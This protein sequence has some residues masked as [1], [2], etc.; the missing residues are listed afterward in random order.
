VLT[1]TGDGTIAT[2]DLAVLHRNAAAEI[3]H[4]TFTDGVLV[5]RA[6]SEA[7]EPDMMAWF[8]DAE[9]FT[10]QRFRDAFAL[11]GARATTLL[12]GYVTIGGLREKV[13]GDRTHYIYRRPSPPK[14][15]RSAEKTD[16]QSDSEPDTFREAK[17]T[18]QSVPDTARTDTENRG[19]PD[20]F[21]K[22]LASK[23]MSR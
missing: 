15:D 1:T 20:D 4:L 13:K 17:R 6:A 19:S 12:D 9:I 10:K 11:S 8:R 21:P 14:P 23:G 7:T 3:F 18:D 16:G 2:R 22:D 5:E